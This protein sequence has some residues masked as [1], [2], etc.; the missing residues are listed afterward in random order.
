MS[1]YYANLKD[2]NE[3]LTNLGKVLVAI[4]CVTITGVIGYALNYSKKII[5]DW[6][7]GTNSGEDE[8]A[9]IAPIKRAPAT[10]KARKTKK[11]AGKKEFKRAVKKIMK[12]AKP[13][14]ETAEP[15]EPAEPA[16][17]AEPTEPAEPKQPRRSLRNKQKNP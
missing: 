15:T 11:K 14:A 17:P 2:L 12:N 8:P 9:K 10:K 16:E 3:E 13:F 4:V 6:Y 1:Q 5:V 7:Q